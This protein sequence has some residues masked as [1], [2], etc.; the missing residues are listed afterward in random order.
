MQVR[1]K[2]GK[3]RNAVFSQWFVAPGGECGAIWPDE[4]WKVARRCGAKHMSKSKCTKHTRVGAPV[5]SKKCKPLCRK[6]HLEVKSAKNRR[7]RTTFGRSDVVSCGRCK[8]F[9]SLST[10][11]FVAFPKTMAG[12]GHSKRIWKDAFRVA[13]AVQKT[14][15]SE[16]LRGL[17]TDFLRGVAW[18]VQHFVWPGI[19]FS[20]QAQNFRQ[21][22]RK[23]RK[24]HWYEAV[25]SA[26]NFLFLKDVSQNCF[27]FDVVNL[28][29]WGSLAE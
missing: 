8:G 6:A 23:K 11:V 3:S 13:G 14:C 12:A 29:N 16:I 24:P 19:T 17:G 28:K 10:R 21:M 15:S 26:P 4:R 20:W 9:F 2:G 22:E 18:Q 5:V 7:P 27:I 1:I 25:S